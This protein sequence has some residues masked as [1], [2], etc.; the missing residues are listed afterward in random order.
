MNSQDWMRAVVEN[1]QFRADAKTV[2]S[3]Y[4]FKKN[5]LALHLVM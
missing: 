5:L 3:I 4:R 1:R 2:K